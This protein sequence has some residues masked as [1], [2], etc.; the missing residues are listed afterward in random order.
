MSGAYELFR[1]LKRVTDVAEEENGM[2][3][4][5]YDPENEDHETLVGA[6]SDPMSPPE[7]GQTVRFSFDVKPEKFEVTTEGGRRRSRLHKKTR[8]SK[9]KRGHTVRR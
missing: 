8:R 5:L 6:F 2:F 3:T 1:A 9:G 4:I 7:E